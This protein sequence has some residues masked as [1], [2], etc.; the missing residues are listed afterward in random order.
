[1]NMNIIFGCNMTITSL[2]S[3]PS[4]PN[5]S[6]QSS[7]LTD[8][9][10]KR[11]AFPVWERTTCSC[12]YL[13]RKPSNFQDKHKS[14]TK[15]KSKAKTKTKAK[16]KTNNSAYKLWYSVHI[17]LVAMQLCLFSKSEPAMLSCDLLQW[18]GHPL[19]HELRKS[20]LKVRSNS[21]RIG[22]IVLIKKQLLMGLQSQ[23]N[24]EYM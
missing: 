5:S 23:A 17:V 4:L 7:F 24:E 19:Y 6:V 20:R 22:C 10:S 21:C 11:L 2:C 3:F 18:V 13:L 16:S 1:M 12:S 8:N 14:K 15:S 9:A